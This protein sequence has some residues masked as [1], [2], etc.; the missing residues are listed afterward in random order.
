MSAARAGQA[1]TPGGRLKPK[2]KTAETRRF[3]GSF[4]FMCQGYYN[5]QAGYRPTFPGEENFQGLIIHPQQWP[6]DLDYTGKRMVVIGS[7]ATAA[8]IVPAVA[9]RVAH[10]TQLQRS[11]SYYLPFDNRVEDPLIQELRRLD[12]PQDWIH[13]IKLRQ[14]L[15]RGR[16]LT[17][18]AIQE[19]DAVK[20]ELLG[21]AAALLPAD[22]DISTHF[23]PRYD[24]WKERLCLLPEGDLFRAIASGKASVVTGHIECFT[25][26][27]IR[28]TS[29]QTLPADIIV[30]ATGIE[31]CGLGNIAFTVDG[32]PVNLPDMWTYKGIMLSDMPNLAWTFGYIRSSWTLR[33][34]LIS[35]Y[36]CRLLK[37]MDAINVRQCT[38]RLRPE[39]RAMQAKPF[40][41]SADF[42]PG[43]MQRGTGRLP[44]QGDHEPW[45]NC[46]NYYLEKTTLPSPALTTACWCSTTHGKDEGMNDDKVKG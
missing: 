34:D 2:L 5:H 13:G 32:S 14:A 35:H 28:L 36:V 45:T 7:G 33:A 23:T 46:Q 16:V 43:Y 19:P 12:V 26:D 44:K 18:R 3:T 8:T 41:D 37:Y 31:L 15:E 20:R 39:D 24:P 11:P 38:P 25:A 21:M 30:T 6:Q 22:Y 42:A 27:G 29:G 4:L 17:E 9:E 40:I 1:Q 10:V